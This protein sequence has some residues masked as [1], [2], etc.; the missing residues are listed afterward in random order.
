MMGA[1]SS[2]A[3]C[4]I[5]LTRWAPACQTRLYQGR[6]TGVPCRLLRVPLAISAPRGGRL[7]V[8]SSY[9]RLPRAACLNKIGGLPCPF[10]CALLTDYHGLPPTCVPLLVSSHTSPSRILLPTPHN[11]TRLAW[12]ASFCV[13]RDNSR[14]PRSAT[15][16]LPQLRQSGATGQET[17]WHQ[18]A[19]SQQRFLLRP[20]L[21]AGR[22]SLSS[23]TTRPPPQRL[24][25]AVQV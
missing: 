6:K 3:L 19:F 7:L 15:G 20:R 11:D 18:R 10:F 4:W 1:S 2:I 23:Y 8:A 24:T 12:T 22:P 13:Q 16:A 25:F 9:Q 21:E 5:A 17:H 14:Q